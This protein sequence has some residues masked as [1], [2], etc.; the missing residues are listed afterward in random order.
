L[1]EDLMNV[2]GIG[3]KSILQLKALVTVR[4]PHGAVKRGRGRGH[5]ACPRPTALLEGGYTVLR[6]CWRASRFH[7]CLALSIAPEAGPRRA[8]SRH[9]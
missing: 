7:T 1:I 4:V 5:L 8:L 2:R 6:R 9:E 3:E